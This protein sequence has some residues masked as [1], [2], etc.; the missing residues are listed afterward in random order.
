MVSLAFATCL[1][2]GSVSANTFVKN[3]PLGPEHTRPESITKAW[4]GKYYVSIQNTND[5]AAS[6]G[7]IVQLDVASGAVTPFVAKGNPLR[8]PRGLAFVGEFLVV[9]DDDKVWKISQAGQVTPL[10]TSFP[11]PPVLFNDAAAE[12]GGKAAFVTEMGPGRNVMRDP[13]KF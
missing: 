6:D 4:G 3:L 13:N 8:N 5:A 2:G 1:V 7:E 9:T 11:F 12:K 10:A